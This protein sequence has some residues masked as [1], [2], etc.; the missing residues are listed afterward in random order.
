MELKRPGKAN[1]LL[2]RC[3]DRRRVSR[4]VTDTGIPAKGCQASIEGGVTLHFTGG[5][6]P[7]STVPG[8]AVDD[9]VVL[10]DWMSIR[11]ARFAGKVCWAKP[12][13]A[14]FHCQ[15]PPRKIFTWRAS[16]APWLHPPR[17][18]ANAGSNRFE[19]A[20]ASFQLLMH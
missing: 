17:A 6:E 11:L 9:L 3:G 10:R 4:V 19:R 14:F 1:P 20:R 16:D 5:S 15:Q 13:H 8:R 12:N 2:L 7:D 18:P